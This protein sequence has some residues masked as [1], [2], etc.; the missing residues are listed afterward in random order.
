MKRQGLP[1]LNKFKRGTIAKR[2]GLRLLNKFKRAII[3]KRPGLR[4]QIELH[5]LRIA[6]NA[7][8]RRRQNNVS[9]TAAF[10]K[11]S[12]Q[13]RDERGSA[14]VEFVVLTLPLFVPFALYLG[15]INSQSQAA[16]DAH[17]LARQAARA[18]ITSPTEDLTAARVNTVVEAF[19]T[20]ILQRHGISS[21]PQVNFYCSASP[22][23]TPGATV[24]ATV[25]IENSTI[26]PAGYL[27]FL[28]STPTKVIAQDNQVVDMW[29]N[30]NS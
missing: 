8:W 20:N 5:G 19:A 12:L 17:N 24:K 25:V 22:C 30:T 2:Q 21:Q 13:L 15:F 6:H 14:V 23:L 26:K 16:Y 10:Q 9:V 28:D 11:I 27:R 3:V 18:F 29:R 1:L 7:A 4:S